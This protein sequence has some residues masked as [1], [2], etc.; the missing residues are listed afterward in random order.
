MT[1]KTLKDRNRASVI[2]STIQVVISG[3]VFFVIFKYLYA[4]IGIEQI[5]IWALVL[6]T[7]S[8]SRIGELGL[9]AGVVRF[10]AQARAYDNERRAEDIVQAVAITLGVFMGCLL[11]VLYP[12]CV[13][14]L[15][16]FIAP[17]N[18][19]LAV[20]ILPIALTSLWVMVLVSVFSG[21]LDGCQRIDLRCIVTGASHLVYLSLVFLLAPKYGLKGVALAQL[22]QAVGLLLATWLSLKSLL[23]GLPIFP[24]HWSGGILREMMGY[25]VSFQFI[26]IMNM[27]FEPVAKALMSKYGGLNLLGYYEMANKLILQGRAV[28]VE[29]SRVLV[30]SIASL[31]SNDEEKAR[32]LFAKS[33]EITFYVAV[34]F[35][36]LLGIS[37]TAICLIWLGR[38]ERTF[39]QFALILNVAWFI[40]TLIG[41]AYFSNLGSGE[42][43]ANLVSHIIMGL[44]GSILAYALGVVF[45]G[46]GVIVGTALGLV[47]GSLFLSINHIRSSGF[48]WRRF[49]VPSG[50][51]GLLVFALAMVLIS[52]GV[53]VWTPSTITVLLA[54]FVC[55]A[56]LVAMG[57]S[58]PVRKWLISR[59]YP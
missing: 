27:L 40:N 39:I 42:L 35:Y 51:L 13:F 1:A 5:G 28:I 14:F 57:W 8:V 32:Q 53:G 12:L 38:Y 58:N 54:G 25:G 29:A 16:K 3:L 44:V 22:G 41:P 50:I 37:L 52:N 17:A 18:L 21:A 46:V 59:S 6:A 20:S 7:T 24:V 11:L 15:G 30:P 36:G 26:S 56:L 47:S 45:G 48:D 19:S 49:I 9:S 4:E 43:R 33:Y 10:V 31:K 2:A 23:R 55:G 34:I